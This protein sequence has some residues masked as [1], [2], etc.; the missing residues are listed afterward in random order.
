MFFTFTGGTTGPIPQVQPTEVATRRFSRGCG[1]LVPHADGRPHRGPRAAPGRC[2]SLSGQHDGGSG[3]PVA[4]TAPGGHAA[5]AAT[6]AGTDGRGA[7]AS[8][9]CGGSAPAVRAGRATPCFPAAGAASALSAAW[10]E[11]AAKL[12][13]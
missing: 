12:C 2:S 9:A 3:C 1:H 4:A 7:E 11:T 6:A 5:A 13:R 10:N 8:H